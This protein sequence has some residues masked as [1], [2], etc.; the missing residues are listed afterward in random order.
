MDYK[1]QEITQGECFKCPYWESYYN[2][3]AYYKLFINGQG[4]EPTCRCPEFKTNRNDT[5]RG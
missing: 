5:E 4:V 3:C 2:F 1:T